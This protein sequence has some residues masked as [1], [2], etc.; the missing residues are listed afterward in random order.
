[1][2]L[3]KAAADTA[4]GKDTLQTKAAQLERLEKQCKRLQ[5]RADTEPAV[6]TATQTEDSGIGGTSGIS[7]VSLLQAPCDPD[8]VRQA[9]DILNLT[10]LEFAALISHR[11]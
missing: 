4:V 1:M 5:A 2:R 10:D 9:Q 11:T 6:A 8:A 3:K 7:G